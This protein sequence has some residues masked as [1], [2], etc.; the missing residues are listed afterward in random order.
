MIRGYYLLNILQSEFISQ[1]INAE[2]KVQSLK[3]TV[4]YLVKLSNDYS[5]T[6]L[7]RNSAGL[8]YFSY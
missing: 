1:V 6:H 8:E 3:Q 4:N 2:R 5:E 7:R